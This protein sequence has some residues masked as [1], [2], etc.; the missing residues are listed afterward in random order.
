MHPNVDYEKL[1]KLV[2]T[3]D[4]AHPECRFQ[5]KNLRAVVQLVPDLTLT[6]QQD[7]NI[8]LYLL[9]HATSKEPN[10]QGSAK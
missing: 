8:R 4:P 5:I 7:L 9:H 3:L 1:R 10:W 2:D 6:Q